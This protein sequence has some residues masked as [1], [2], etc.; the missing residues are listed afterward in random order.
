MPESDHKPLCFSIKCMDEVPAASEHPGEIEVRKY[1]VWDEAKKGTVH[2]C[3]SD[4]Q[5]TRCLAEFWDTLSNQECV[6]TVATKFNTYVTQAAKRSLIHKKSRTN[7]KPGQF[8]CNKWYDDEC[9]QLRKSLNVLSR[10]DNS[11][12]QDSYDTR[13]RDYKALVQNKNRQY[14]ND[15]FQNLHSS[16]KS[17][18]M[19]RILKDNGPK[20]KTVIPVSLDAFTATFENCENMFGCD[21]FDSKHQDE[22]EQFMETYDNTLHTTSKNQVISDIM[23]SLFTYEEITQGI[24]KLKG[25]K[26]CGLDGLPAEIVKAEQE[27]LT[28]PICSLFNYVLD[29]GKFPEQWVNGLITPVHK[30]QSITNPENYRRITVLPLLGK[31]FEIVVNNRVTFMKETLHSADQY[32][33]G[34]KKGSMTSDNMFLLLGCIQRSTALKQPLYVC[35]VDFRRAFGTVNRDI[36]C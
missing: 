28:Y 4:E 6:N 24:Q 30:G 21:Y 7:K 2:E 15:I 29:S 1:F 32:N 8:P 11:V 31:L 10:G 25:K 5:G 12:E 22:I 16:Q 9:K 23:N 26:S 33:G 14:Q 3:L 13:K 20:K 27:I 17:D 36:S 18:D 34:F 35:Y 19:W